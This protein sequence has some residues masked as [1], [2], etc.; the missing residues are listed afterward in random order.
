MQ[1]LTQVFGPAQT[2]SYLLLD[3]GLAIW[4]DP[5]PS[6]AIWVD[7][8]LPQDTL[9]VA[10]LLTHTHWDHI[11]DLGKSRFFEK[12]PIYVHPLD[13]P[14]I[15]NPGIDGLEWPSTVTKPF[16]KN[17]VFQFLEEGSRWSIG[18]NSFTTLHTPGHS[19]GSC[20][21]YSETLDLLISGDTLFATGWGRVDLP[22]SDPLAMRNSLKRLSQLSPS[23]RFFPGHGPSK[24]LSSLSWLK[25][26]IEEDSF[27][28]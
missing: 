23:L 14:N 2:Q 15:Q 26:A 20:V 25:G 18:K 10:T 4:I 5:A 16:S 9:A 3:E 28:P 13:F 21:F 22:H 24:I 1:I 12:A 17:A 19:P 7:Q 8:I 6:S 11:S 27:W